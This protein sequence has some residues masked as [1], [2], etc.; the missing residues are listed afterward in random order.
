[1]RVEPC[2]SAS[3]LAGTAKPEVTP[4]IIDV[5]PRPT[6]ALQ[7]HMGLLELRYAPYKSKHWSQSCCLLTVVRSLQHIDVPP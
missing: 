4:Q 1:M 3:S 2:E 6:S 7:L 5:E